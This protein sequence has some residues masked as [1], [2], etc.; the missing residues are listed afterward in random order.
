MNETVFFS[1]SGTISEKR[2]KNTCSVMLPISSKIV[3]LPPFSWEFSRIFRGV[4]FDDCKKKTK[5]S[6]KANKTQRTNTNFLGELL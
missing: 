4:A 1:S 3:G 2:F 6:G 5:L